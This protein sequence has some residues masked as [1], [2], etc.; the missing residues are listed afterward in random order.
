MGC[1]APPGEARPC[2]AVSPLRGQM[3]L[4]ALIAYLCLILAWEGPYL[5]SLWRVGLPGQWRSIRQDGAF[6][7]L[8]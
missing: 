7:L 2:S 4:G 1:P 3:A 6:L 8:W 5:R